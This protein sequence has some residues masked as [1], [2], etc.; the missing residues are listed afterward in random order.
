MG[1]PASRD[2]LLEMLYYSIPIGWNSTA[3]SED[4][5]KNEKEIEAAQK[6]NFWI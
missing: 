5:L 6:W 2:K 3:M 4:G 1:Q